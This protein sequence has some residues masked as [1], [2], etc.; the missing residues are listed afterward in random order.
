MK[1]CWVPNDDTNKS[2]NFF[3]IQR[4]KNNVQRQFW[5]VL[6]DRKHKMEIKNPIMSLNRLELNLKFKVPF[7][8]IT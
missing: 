7:Q 2:S 1:V 8:W 4:N 5:F 6:E 3:R